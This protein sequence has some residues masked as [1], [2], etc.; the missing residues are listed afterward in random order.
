MNTSEFLLD[1]SA[2]VDEVAMISDQLGV[3]NRAATAWPRG[4]SLNIIVRQPDGK[5]LGGV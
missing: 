2:T 1:H 4:I 3:F 5:A